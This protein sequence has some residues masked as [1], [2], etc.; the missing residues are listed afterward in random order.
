[1]IMINGNSEEELILN[2]VHDEPYNEM[3]VYDGPRPETP[4]EKSVRLFEKYLNETP[5][6]EIL[7][8]FDKIDKSAPN[9]GSLE[10]YFDEIGDQLGMQ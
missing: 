2:L 10:E 7:K 6:A 3:E 5:E 9:N 8:L 4:I 1:M